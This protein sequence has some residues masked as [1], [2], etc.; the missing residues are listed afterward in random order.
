MANVAAGAVRQTVLST[1]GTGA[2]GKV[3]R[4]RHITSQIGYKLPGGQERHR[5]SGGLHV[6]DP[7]GL[8]KGW[9]PRGGNNAHA[10]VVVR[11]KPALSRGQ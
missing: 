9:V 11:L 3:E 10:S 1:S 2:C 7:G 4:V 8:V 6:V 5:R